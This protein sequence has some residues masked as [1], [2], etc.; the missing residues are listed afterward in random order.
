MF[1]VLSKLLNFLTKPFLVLSL[2]L[3]LSYVVKNKLWAKRIRIFVLIS[4]LI[5][6]NGIIINELMLAWEIAPVALA[7]I[8]DNTYETAIVLGGTTDPE[9]E[10]KDRLYFHKGADRVTHAIHLYK[11]GKVKKILFSGGKSELFEDS[12]RDNQTILD[13]YIMCGVAPEDI[14][15][16]NKSRNTHE[17][18]FYSAELL[19]KNQ[20]HILITSAF[21]MRRSVACYT[22]EG[23]DVLPFSCDFN[24]VK[25]DDRFSLSGMIPSLAAMSGWEILLKE[26]VGMVAYKVSGYI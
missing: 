3:I 15:I 19:D 9:R 7:D 24:T 17:N 10:P 23:L 5:T 21:H 22:K 16:E 18:A 6:S 25:E 13:F 14:I 12:E 2:L 26:W 20:Q 11:A 8:P 4:F 1:F